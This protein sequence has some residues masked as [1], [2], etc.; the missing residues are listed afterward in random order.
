M[1]LRLLLGERR[2]RT[3]NFH[4]RGGTSH[5]RQQDHRRRRRCQCRCRRMRGGCCGHSC[6]GHCH[7]SLLSR[8]LFLI[9]VSR[10]I[11]VVCCWKHISIESKRPLS[12]QRHLRRPQRWRSLSPTA[13]DVER[14]CQGG[15]RHHITIALAIALD[16][17]ACP[18]TLSSSPSLLLPSP[19]PV[20]LP[21]TLAYPC[22]RHHHHHPLRLHRQRLLTIIVAVT[23]AL[24]AVAIASSS[25]AIL[26][27]VTIA[28]ATLTLC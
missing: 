14:C 15:P 17:V 20:L 25:P 24:A 11:I 27:T 1:Q 12:P 28:L 22:C 2:R 6:P 7:C 16:P 23:I 26:I 13:P 18:P 3:W 9:F 19:M 4:C 8:Q 5:G 21:A 10:K